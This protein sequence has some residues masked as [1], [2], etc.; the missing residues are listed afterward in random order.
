MVAGSN[1]TGALRCVFEQDWF[2]PGRT[3]KLLTGT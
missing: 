1:L 3:E 2:N